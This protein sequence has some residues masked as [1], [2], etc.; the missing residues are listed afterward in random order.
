M[1][2][3]CILPKVQLLLLCYETGS[4]KST[5]SSARPLEKHTDRLARKGK[6]HQQHCRSLPPCAEMCRCWLTA[7][8]FGC[9]ERFKLFVI[10]LLWNFIL[11]FT[12]R[13][14]Q[15]VVLLLPLCCCCCVYF[16]ISFRGLFLF[17][18]RLLFSSLPTNFMYE[19]FFYSAFVF[20]KGSSGFTG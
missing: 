20:K 10:S 15:T 7:P 19:T 2:Q 12:L 11:L 5:T 4:K 8:Q 9:M 14:H 3:H 16:Y 13:E 18:F 1:C 17:L 6:A